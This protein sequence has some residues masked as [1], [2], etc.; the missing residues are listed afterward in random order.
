MFVCAHGLYTSC[1]PLFLQ[2]FARSVGSW[3]LAHPFPTRLKPPFKHPTHIDPP[4]HH[5]SFSVCYRGKGISDVLRIPTLHRLRAPLRAPM[6]AMYQ[7]W[8]G[9]TIAICGTKSYWLLLMRCLPAA[10]HSSWPM[11]HLSAMRLNCWFIHRDL[12][13]ISITNGWLLL[14]SC[15][16][17]LISWRVCNRMS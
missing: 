17:C 16:F 4:M 8:A 5:A 3:L 12:S 1:A 9:P 11:I 13:L 14:S 6:V 2:F 7:L 15:Y 10:S